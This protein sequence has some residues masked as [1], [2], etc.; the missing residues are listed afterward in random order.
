MQPGE[1]LERRADRAVV[2]DD[3]LL[4]GLGPPADV[5]GARGQNA[6]QPPVEQAVGHGGDAQ[7]V[8]DTPQE[9]RGGVGAPIP[10]PPPPRGAARARAGG[11]LC[12]AV[13]PPPPEPPDRGG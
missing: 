12:N 1:A 10:P 3:E 8:A 7:P 5:G 2:A 6:C 9:R 4:T 13:R 11:G